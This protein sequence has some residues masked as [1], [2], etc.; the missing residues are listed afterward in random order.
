MLAPPLRR[1]DLLVLGALVALIAAVAVLAPAATARADEQRVFVR[2]IPDEATWRRYSKTLNADTFGKCIIDVKSDDIYYIDV[3]L[4]RIHADFVLGVLLKLPWTAENVR[5]YNRNYERD[6][7]RFILC[8]LTHHLKVDRWT[9]SFW[10]GDKIDAAGVLRVAK[11]LNETFFVKN[12]TFR[13]DSPLQEKVAAEVKKKG[14]KTV[15]NDEIYKASPY[16]AFNKGRAVGRLH[17]VPAGTPYEELIFDRSEIALL[18]EAYPDISPVAG[19]LS[20]RAST[21]LAHVNLR[22]TAWGVP[23][24]SFTKAREEYA[25]LD[26]EVVYYEVGDAAMTLRKATEKEIADFEARLQEQRTVDLPPAN[27]SNPNL[28][29]ITRMRAKDVTSYGAKAANLGEIRTAGLAGVDIPDGFGIPFF[30]YLRHMKQNGLDTRVD[31]MLADPHWKS[32]AAWRKAELEK[33]RKAILEAPIDQEVLAAIYKRVRVRLGGKGVF[34]RSSTNAEDLEGFNGAGLYDTVPNV[35]GKK[36]LGEAIKTVWASLWNFRAVE[37]RT[38][39]GIDQR[40]VYAGVFVQIGVAATAAGVL[41]TRNLFDPSDDNS[42][43]INAKWGL[44][45]RVVEGTKV[46]EQIIYDTS[47]EGTKIVSRSDDPTMLVFDDQ[48]GIR[49]VPV[50]S[51]GVIL[52]EERAK[53]L[54]TAV[55]TF[56][57]LFAGVPLDVEWVLEGEKV[58]IVQAR[59]YIGK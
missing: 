40:Q 11:R 59:P 41:I 52:S 25:A 16:Q 55:Q 50:P 9:F 10:E 32:D 42:F 17:V 54:A 2:S 45:M 31:A 47:N 44:G 48:G 27:L 30:Y 3:S 53:R 12:L 56:R 1:L 51:Q 33:L 5:E 46:P 21:P 35:R 18:Q 7:P 13:P 14:V 24:A 49:E 36:Q 19:I 38:L 4:F 58:W 6:K 8:Y 26:G 23:N 39:Y 37:E 34:V 29:M 57:P 28:R 20:T 43:T 15:T 22:C